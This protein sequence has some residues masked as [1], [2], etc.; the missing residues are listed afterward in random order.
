M[1]SPDA[2]P[3]AAEPAAG[4]SATDVRARLEFLESTGH[5]LLE[6]GLTSGQT[7]HALSRYGIDLGVEALSISAFGRML[8]LEA[9]TN[10]GDTV[11]TS[12][13]ARTL[14]AIDCTRSRELTR[15]AERTAHTEVARMPGREAR[16]QLTVA[17][18]VADRLRLTA[19]PW[20]IVA[21]GTTMLAFFISMQVGVS[22]EAWV[23]AALV[24]AAASVVGVGT[25]AARMPK[26]F[27]VAVQSTA[28]GA[29]ATMLVQW[30]FVDPVG[31]AAAIAVNWLLLLPLPQVIGAVTDAIDGDH[32]SAGTRVANVAVAAVG[33]VIGG[34]LTF[35][36]GEALGMEHPR[37][38]ALPTM[39]WYLIL[40][41]SALGAIANSFANGGRLNLV[42]PAAF[43]GVATGATNQLLLSSGLPAVWA[44][45]LAAT[46]LGLLSA[47]IA[48]RTGYPSQVLAL[49]GVTGALL[50]GIPVFFGILQ[51]MGEGSG[52][53]SF[54]TAGLMSL[55]I[56]IGVALG[57]Y[58][59]RLV[60]WERTAAAGSEET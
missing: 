19:T 5:G 37:L 14:E 41:F 6:S 27:A 25:A 20:W 4:L 54:G 11:S 34:T 18:R 45:A 47:R 48:V 46:V 33:I 28:A 51:Q 57:G 10:D 9:A 40:V 24:Q 8:I 58:L 23:T 1:S 31:A 26:L 3:G 17:K 13:A 35:A 44:T 42:A 50:P 36:L 29:L 2:A 56:G 60:S 59:S 32:L 22:W 21:L 30:D 15:L 12:G 43:L 39:P 7:E 49:M 16:E 55:A 53:A 38:D 52:L